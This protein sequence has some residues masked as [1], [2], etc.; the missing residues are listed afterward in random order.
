M[1]AP[2]AEIPIQTI[3]HI[4]THPNL[5]GTPLRGALGIAQRAGT[6][7]SRADHLAPEVACRVRSGHSHGSH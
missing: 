4:S 2:G 1:D 5:G 6:V 7:Q 3:R